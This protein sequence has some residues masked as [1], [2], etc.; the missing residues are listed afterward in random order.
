V[1]V[2]NGFVVDSN[3]DRKPVAEC[4]VFGHRPRGG[5]DI[6][7]RGNSVFVAG[8]RECRDGSW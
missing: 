8:N 4:D 3:A 2:D 7:Y 6:V 1:G 5:S